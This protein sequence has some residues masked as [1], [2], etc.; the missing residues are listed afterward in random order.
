MRTGKLVEAQRTWAEGLVAREEELFDEWFRTA[1]VI[2]QPGASVP[3]DGSDGFHQRERA[4]A[5]R[6]RAEF[7][8]HPMLSGLTTEEAFVADALSQ[9]GC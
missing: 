8:A 5:A 9:A 4:T 7:R 3:P 6:A 1:P 2:V